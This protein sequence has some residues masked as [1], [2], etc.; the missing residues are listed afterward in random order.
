MKTPRT[1]AERRRLKKAKSYPPDPVSAEFARQLERE[2]DAARQAIAEAA[3]HLSGFLG[4][5]SDCLSLEQ[6]RA[7]SATLAKLKP[8]TTP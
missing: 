4:F 7:L 1:D 6:V 8:F 2:R 5:H 3:S